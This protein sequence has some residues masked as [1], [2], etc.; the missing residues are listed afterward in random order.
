MAANLLCLSLSCT[1]LPKCLDQLLIDY[2][3]YTASY[4]ITI[5]VKIVFKATHVGTVILGDLELLRVP[6]AASVL[7]HHR[8]LLLTLPDCNGEK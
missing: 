5:C 8:D 7:L 2:N 3:C 1:L 4:L 6:A